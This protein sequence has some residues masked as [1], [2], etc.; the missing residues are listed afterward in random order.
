ALAQQLHS[1]LVQELGL[2]EQFIQVLQSEA[3]A[4]TAADA[5]D[6]LNESTQH[7]DRCAQALGVT[8]TL[9]ETLLVQLGYTAD[10]A[11]LDAA[12]Q[13]YPLLLPLSRQ[14]YQLASQARELN[15]ANGA[16]ID[17]YLK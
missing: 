17:L 6:A 15:L 2:V 5:H 16:V 10:Q 3:A 12:A 4:L 8:G 1:C 14:L 9:R 7:K 13:A 11:G